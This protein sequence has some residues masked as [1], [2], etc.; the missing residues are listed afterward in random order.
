MSLSA[1]ALLGQEIEHDAGVELTGARPHGQ[2][3]ERGEAHGALDALPSVDGAHGRAAAEMGH[4][5]AALCNVRRQFRQPARD[6]FVGQPV[7]TVTADAFLVEAFGQSVAV[8]NFG[9]AAMKRRIEAG[10][11]RKLR[12]PLPERVRIGPRL[13]GWW[14]GASGAKACS[15]SITAS[16]MRIGS[17]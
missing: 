4:D 7:E 13:F 11:L 16:S 1:H 10:D 17:L 14:R 6:I 3:V 9:M 15:R 12:L 8:G 2:T 5:H